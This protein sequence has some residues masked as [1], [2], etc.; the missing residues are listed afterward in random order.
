MQLHDKQKDIV[1]STARFKVIRAGRRSGKTTLEVE[2]MAFRALSKANTPIFYIAPTQV[3]ARAIIWEALKKRL[4]QVGDCGKMNY[5]HE[6][7]ERVVE[8]P[9]PV[10]FTDER[11]GV[12]K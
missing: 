7:E 2:D 10:V 11:E 6:R 12:T 4:Y 9:A 3:Q 8:D 1:T 5:K